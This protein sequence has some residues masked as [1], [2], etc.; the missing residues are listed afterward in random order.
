VLAYNG[1]KAFQWKKGLPME[2]RPSNGRKA[3]QWK[4]GL[5]MEE[6]PSNGRMVFHG[7]RAWNRRSYEYG[8]TYS[9]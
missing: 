4:K 5:P 1:R 9:D 7:R 2:E 6:R 8:G 3:F